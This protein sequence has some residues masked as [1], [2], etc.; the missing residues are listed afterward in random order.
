[1]GHSEGIEAVYTT[2]K[3]IPEDII[4]QMRKAYEEA[5]DAY[6]TIPKTKMVS[7]EEASNEYKHMYLI[8]YG[9][10]TE[11]EVYRLGDLS[12]YT[13]QQLKE[14]VEKS[15]PTKRVTAERYP[16]GK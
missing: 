3:K 8:Q 11:E 15:K 9:E 6:L 7:F 4:E 12:R 16:N 13:F 5:S 1:M 10:M 14:M 2:D